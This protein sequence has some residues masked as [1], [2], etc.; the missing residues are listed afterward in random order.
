MTCLSLPHFFM[1][2]TIKAKEALTRSSGL[3]SGGPRQCGAVPS[4]GI[5]VRAMT[6]PQAGC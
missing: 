6:L 4:Q 1:Q 2:R 5:S 3:G